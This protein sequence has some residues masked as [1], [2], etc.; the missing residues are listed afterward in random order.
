MKL[1]ITYRKLKK[2]KG[3]KQNKHVETK[4]HGSKKQMGNDVFKGKSESTSRL[5]KI[6]TQLSKNL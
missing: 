6:E 3:K 4:Q 1:E 5:R 2:K